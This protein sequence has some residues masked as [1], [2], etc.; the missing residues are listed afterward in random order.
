M[1]KAATMT[2]TAITAAAVETCKT[3]R[4]LT[5][6]RVFCLVT[7]QGLLGRVIGQLPSDPQQT[8]LAV[9]QHHAI[10]SISVSVT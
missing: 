5:D 4:L 6:L 7:R 3:W 10:P 8:I 2:V 1:Q 9:L